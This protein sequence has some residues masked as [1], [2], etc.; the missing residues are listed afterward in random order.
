MECVIRFISYDMMG[1]QFT[2]NADWAEFGDTLQD[3][4]E[5]LDYYRAIFDYGTYGKEPCNLKESSLAYFNRA[6][7]PMIDKQ[8]N[9][10]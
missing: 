1:R 2:F 10:Q 7:R 6:V 8:C 4:Q 3:M 9:K 5:Q